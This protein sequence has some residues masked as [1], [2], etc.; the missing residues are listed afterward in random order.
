[1]IK[2]SAFYSGERGFKAP[3]SILGIRVLIHVR[4]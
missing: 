3:I 2:Q 4:A 1:M